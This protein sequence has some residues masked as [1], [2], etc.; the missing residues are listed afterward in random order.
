MRILLASSERFAGCLIDSLVRAGHQVVGV[1]SPARGIYERQFAGPRFWLYDLRGWDI[2]KCCQR[3]DI[4]FR[5]SRYLEDGAIHAFIKS[6]RADMLIL[7]GW[8]TMVKPET[9]ALF[10]RGSINIHPSLL[11]KLRGADPLFCL[12]DR[13][14][15][16]FGLSFHKPVE[17]LDAGPLYL[18]IP[19]L[20]SDLDSYD[21]LYFK[22]LEGIFRFLPN[23]LEVLL[24]HPQG[25]P[26]KGQPTQVSPFR[27]SMCYL[28]LDMNL[29][30]VMRRMRACFSHHPM[31]T[32]CG[33]HLLLFSTC[34]VLHSKRPR[35][36]TPNSIQRVGIFGLEVTLAGRYVRLGGMH[37]LGKPRSL[38]P[39]LLWLNI[40]PGSCLEPLKTVTHMAKA[41]DLSS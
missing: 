35:F 4:E 31:I 22:I 17:E 29:E 24:K 20:R 12:V 7:F 8:P 14:L 1:V 5:V 27:K 38:T 36:D 6:E 10:S 41:Y 39:L 18:Q 21:D 16:G 23:A 25:S 26:Q 32:A 34:R 33:S 11:P 9:L 13:N 2:L 28:D 37:F 30:E 40:R 19:L 3:R 15:D